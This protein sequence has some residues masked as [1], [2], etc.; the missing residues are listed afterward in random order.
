MP[1]ISSSCLIAVARTSN[2]MSNMSG[3]SEHACLVPDFKENTFSFSLLSMMLAV[4]LSY[5]AF[6]KLRY[7]G[8]S[9]QDGG[10]GRH[11]VSPHT[12][13]RTPP[14]LKTKNNQN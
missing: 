13:K 11:T 6:F 4:D 5:M 7:Q 1:F 12:I 3:E 8:T 2:T 9:S 10:I 14:N